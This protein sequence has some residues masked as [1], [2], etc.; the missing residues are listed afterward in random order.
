MDL[1][2]G[3]DAV[4]GVTEGS[5]GGRRQ[6][7]PAVLGDQA[8]ARRDQAATYVFLGGLR[9][10]VRCINTKHASVYA[11]AVQAQ[12]LT[13]LSAAALYSKEGHKQVIGLTDS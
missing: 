4:L 2:T 7:E 6:L 5:S 3:M 10:F 11:Q 1:E 13:M 8:A 12:A 9:Q